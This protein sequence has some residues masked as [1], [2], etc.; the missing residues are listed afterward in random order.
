MVDVTRLQK[1]VQRYRSRV[2]AIS[3]YFKPW[4]KMMSVS[5]CIEKETQD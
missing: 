5:E 4:V 1:R 3:V 2:I